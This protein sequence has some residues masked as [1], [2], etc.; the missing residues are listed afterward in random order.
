MAI[1][2]AQNASSAGPANITNSDVHIDKSMLEV[3][4]RSYDYVQTPVVVLDADA[5]LVYSN[6]SAVARTSAIESDV[7]EASGVG[8]TELLVQHVEN[9]RQN[10]EA[11]RSERLAAGP[12][13]MRTHVASIADANGEPVAYVVDWEDVG[14][15]EANAD[16]MGQIAA[17]GKVQAVIEFELDGTI[18]SAN[19][20]F[21]GAMG[22]SLEEIQG[23]HHSMFADE[24]YATSDEY[25]AFWGALRA[26]EYQTGEFKRVGKGGREVWIQASYNPIL[27]L[28]GKPFKVV[29]YATDVTEHRLATANYEGQ[30][31]AIGKAQA[32]IEF[33]LDGTI[34]TANENFLGAM[35]YSLDEIRGQ[36]HSMFAEEQYATSAEYGAFWDALR[37]GEYQTGEYKR[38]GRGGREVWIQASYNPILDLNGVPFKVVKYATDVTDHKLATADYEGQ[39]DAICKAQ[40]VIE[41]ELDGTI[42]SANENFL[43]VM[44][45]SLEEIQGQH[46]SLF[47]EPSY[48]SGPE[49]R[50]FWDALDAGE[51]QT[52]EYRRLGKGGKE[53]WIQASYNPILDLNGVP[54]KVVKYA[55]DITAQKHAA[56]RAAEAAKA[57]SVVESAPTNIMMANL[58]LVIEYI[59]PSMAKGLERIADELPVPVD[60]VVGSSIDIF[61]KNPRHQ[62]R[63]LAEDANLPHTA[64]LTIGAETAVL[65]I[66]PINSLDGEKVGIMVTWDFITER[67]ALE[68]ER[69]AASERE[70]EEARVLQTKVDD[71]LEVV[72]SAA[73]GDL[74]HDVFVAGEDAI[75]QM[76][77]GLRDFMRG[78]RDNLR[79]IRDNGARVNEASNALMEVSQ[80]MGA[81]AEETSA[82]AD[83]VSSSAQTVS[84]SLQTISAAI[85]EM[86]ASIGEI[87]SNASKASRMAA[88]AVDKTHRANSI[89]DKLGVS[90]SEVGDVVKLI[91]SIA[92][93]T[94]LLALNATIE[95]ARAGEVGRG[96]A[97]VANEVK[98]LAKETAR[99]T[100]VISEKIE[101]IQ[102]DTAEATDATLAVNT[103][104]QEINDVQAIIATAVEQQT[105]TTSEMSESI[106]RAAAGGI[107][108]SE[109]ISGVAQA[110]RDTAQGASGAQSSAGELFSMADEQQE[111]V[112]RFK[113]DLESSEEGTEAMGRLAELLQGGDGAEMVQEL[114]RLLQRD[115]A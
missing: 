4:C 10:S 83:V 7:M 73:D 79:V 50:A 2:R 65:L 19:E 17:I 6:A 78:L 5:K 100:E 32:V 62:R 48:A 59:N 58:D 75:G 102:A 42:I 97:V 112:S 77:E 55:S 93:Q 33:E 28:N 30:I 8:V 74:T 53:V 56:V 85:E 91:T 26:G 82:Q 47:A 69:R 45:Y 11:N 76:G 104:I 61:H 81:N 44:G 39:I 22:Y 13:A 18:I 98:D 43:G 106:T 101:N 29:K 3:V 46:H 24:Q 54:F 41:F 99:S 103:L 105:A 70:R 20:N 92:E 9:A 66:S 64:Q 108:I 63:F 57:Q 96:F 113:L 14:L 111:L 1:D 87:S 115:D 52:G 25:N 40:A 80:Q 88:D 109:N 38:L 31:D 36:H 15:R 89:I 49:Y 110:A 35:G 67:L 71:M 107:E 16:L 60:E 114:A 21:L 12:V 72:R 90:T 34:V 95:A 37:A 23:Q 84:D 27:D 51:H 68:E 86:T 94:N